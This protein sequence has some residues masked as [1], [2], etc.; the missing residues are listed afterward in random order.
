MNLETEIPET[1][2]L[3]MKDID[4]YN[5][6]YVMKQIQSITMGINIIKNNLIE[7]VISV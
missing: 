1:L 6:L 3:E 5:E 4:T 2:F 7:V